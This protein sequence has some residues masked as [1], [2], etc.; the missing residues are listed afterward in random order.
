MQTRVGDSNILKKQTLLVFASVLGIY[1]VLLGCSA[2]GPRPKASE[3]PPAPQTPSHSGRE[4]YEALSESSESEALSPES[5][6]LAEAEGYHAVAVLASARGDF[7]EAEYNFEKA[8]ELLA[9]LDPETEFTHEEQAQIDELLNRMGQDYQATVQKRGTN[10]SPPEMSAFMMRFEDLESL[11]NWKTYSEMQRALEPDHVTY[12][13]PVV[14]N[15]RVRNCLFYFQTIARANMEL[16]LQRAGR[17]LPLMQEIFAS[18]GLPTD[19]CYLP[20]IE[21]GFN[22]HAYSYA[23]AMGPWQ[24]I[25]STGKNY[26][27]QKDWWKDE[28]RDFVRSTHAAARYL[29]ALYE[30][31]GDWYLALAAYN[32]GEGRVGRTIQKQ[33]T[34]DFWQMRLRKQT[35]NYVPLYLASLIIAKEPERFGFHVEPDPPLRWDEAEVGKPIELKVLA[36]YLGCSVE[37]LQALNPE[38]LRGVTPPQTSTY[39][40][41]IPQGKG[42]LFASAYELIPQSERTEWVRHTVAR[43]ESLSGIARRYGTSVQ[44]IRDAN[45]LKSNQI[46]AGRDLVVPVPVGAGERT[47]SRPVMA[48]NTGEYRVR[49]GDTMSK[50]A[51]AHGVSVAWLA[52]HNHISSRGKIYPGQILKVPGGN[53]ASVSENAQAPAQATY[54]DYRV[55]SGENLT[56]IAGRYGM[57]AQRLAQINNISVRGKIY[58]GQTLRVPS[59]ARSGG[60]VTYTVRRGDNLYK[61]AREFGIAVSELIEFNGIDNP[62]HIPV[63]TTLTIPTPR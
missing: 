48:S 33:K 51:G 59:V 63:G 39:K 58:P 34:K 5:V 32:G 45:K 37:E 60:K 44:A 56:E 17:Y 1:L 16:Y 3:V 21:S 2:A 41:R 8:L 40:L 28:R 22:T 10:L 47:A 55:K 62:E 57:S 24:F 43:G 42:A 9:E 53:T 23:R 14:W 54:V 61:I 19:L 49:A 6:L 26:G 29:G 50:I 7:D 18:Y 35:E 12:D 20:I 13:V 25:S 31:F 27:L 4:S 11:R 52:Q 36:R 15:E 46:V 30:M 38:L